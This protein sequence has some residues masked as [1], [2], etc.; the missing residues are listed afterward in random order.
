[1]RPTKKLTAALKGTDHVILIF[2]V[3]ESSCFQGLARMDKA[4]D[5][6]FKPE[7]FKN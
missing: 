5:P 1:M 4:P 6:S 2:S 7:L 3:N